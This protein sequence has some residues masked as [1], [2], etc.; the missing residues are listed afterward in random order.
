MDY[1]TLEEWQQAKLLQMKKNTENYKKDEIALYE[2]IKLPLPETV[3][4][5]IHHTEKFAIELGEWIELLSDN[6]KSKLVKLMD[7]WKIHNAYDHFNL[8]YKIIQTNLILKNLYSDKKMPYS[9]YKY[10]LRLKTLQKIAIKKDINIYNH[11]SPM[12]QIYF[13]KLTCEE[14]LSNYDFDHNQ[15]TQ[16][17]KIK[18]MN[19]LIDELIEL[20][21]SDN[22][23]QD[24]K[25]R[26]DTRIS[27]RTKEFYA[28]EKEIQDM[29]LKT[30]QAYAKKI[31]P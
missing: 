28:I 18:I 9:D 2:D 7:D 5:Y 4:N 17:G 27:K 24:K 30:H 16:R 10:H 23:A 12:N 25:Y 6:F 20:I 22:F 31:E 8:I 13:F 1:K 11:A 21:V 26:T 29:T 19:E 15:S 14:L 3:A